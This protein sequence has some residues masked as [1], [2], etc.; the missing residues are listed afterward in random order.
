MGLV[1]WWW[2]YV[3][4]LFPPAYDVTADVQID[5][6][7]VIQ[8]SSVTSG[9]DLCSPHL[10]FLFL[11][12]VYLFVPWQITSGDGVPDTDGDDVFTTLDV[13]DQYGDAV[14]NHT[15]PQSD[16]WCMVFLSDSGP[17]AGTPRAVA[18]VAETWHQQF[19]SRYT[20]RQEK[21]SASQ[22]WGC[23]KFQPWRW[24]WWVCWLV[25]LSPLLSQWYYLPCHLLM[26]SSLMS[27]HVVS[28]AIL[29]S[30]LLS[31]WCYSPLL[32]CDISP[33]FLVTLSPMLSVISCCLEMLSPLRL[34]MLSPLLWFYRPCCLVM[35]SPL[36]PCDL[37]SPVVLWC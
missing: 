22:K 33:V 12:S 28:P 7:L 5:N 34:V 37:I 9:N 14:R 36:L 32:S 27:F 11:S 23:Q 13:I 24:W 35:L 15:Q 6:S 29:S 10:W 26:L 2:L 30:P 8:N 25:M 21:T 20:K 3:C 16:I 31:W 1:S 4:C 18:S 17:T 19:Q